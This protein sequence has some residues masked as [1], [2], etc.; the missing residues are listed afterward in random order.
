MNAKLKNKRFTENAPEIVIQNEIKKKDD[1]L[2][3]ID[4]LN[5]RL[6]NLE[7]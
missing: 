7:N 5:S 4:V 1:A 2:S 6:N 3:K